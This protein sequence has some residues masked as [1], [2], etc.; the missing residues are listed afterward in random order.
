MPR[1]QMGEVPGPQGVL[2]KV[3]AP[4]GGSWDSGHGVVCLGGNQHRELRPC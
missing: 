2:G 1:V 4:G 3:T